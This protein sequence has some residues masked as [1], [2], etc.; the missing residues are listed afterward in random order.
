MPSTY[1][2]RHGLAGYD[3]FRTGLTYDDVLSMLWSSD[4]DS[5]HWKYR[6]RGTVLGFWHQL[7]QDMWDQVQA[8]QASTDEVPF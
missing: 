8:E 4:P 3:R 5:A 7:K 6:R 2:K 1:G